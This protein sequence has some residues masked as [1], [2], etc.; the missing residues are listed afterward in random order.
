MLD[1]TLEIPSNLRRVLDQ[2]AA[3]A[4]RAGRDPAEITLIAASKTQDAET[5]RAGIR[6]GIRVCGENRVQEMLPH[7]EENAYEGAEL[8]FIG[9]LQTNKVRQV[10]GQV[11]LIQS[12]GSVRLAEAIEAQAEKLGIVQDILLEV[13]IGKEESKH[14][15]FPEA[16]P[17]LAAAAGQMP[18]LRLRGLMCMPP[19]SATEAENRAFFA[20]TYQLFVDIRSK[21]GDN[22]PDVDCLSMGMSGDFAVAIEEGATMV[23]VGTALFGPRKPRQASM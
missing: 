3:A 20:Q 4:H 13:N 23:R 2:I 8:H 15:V 10:V 9:H 11:A 21:I 14:G 5:I 6:A 17:A 12:V 22:N 7:L 19:A 16:L 18:H 1:Q